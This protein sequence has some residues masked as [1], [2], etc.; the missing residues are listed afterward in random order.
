MA[1]AVT[2]LSAVPIAVCLLLAW[3]IRSREKVGLIAGYDGGLPPERE[4]ELARDAAAV[5]VVA[6]A[7]TSLLVVDAWTR[8][9]P[10]PGLL[11]TILIAAAVAWF[12]WKWN[13]REPDRD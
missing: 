13:V 8:G 6:A 1:L 2:L 3:A 12:L 9:V 5:L 10:R 4:A 11:V 7:A